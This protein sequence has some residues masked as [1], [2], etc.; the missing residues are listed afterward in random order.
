[1]ARALWSPRRHGGWPVEGGRAWGPGPWCLRRVAHD[2]P[3]TGPSTA[4]SEG[5]WPWQGPVARGAD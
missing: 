5:S 4:R 1:M 3:D 2:D